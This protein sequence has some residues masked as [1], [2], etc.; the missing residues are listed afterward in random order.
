MLYEYNIK[1]LEKGTQEGHWL[2]NC[3]FYYRNSIVIIKLNI[4]FVFDILDI[5]KYEY[6]VFNQLN[7]SYN[8]TSI[9]RRNT[10]SQYAL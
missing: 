4:F 3:L 7:K 6:Y 9:A 5:Y 2:I 8:S 1:E 10:Q